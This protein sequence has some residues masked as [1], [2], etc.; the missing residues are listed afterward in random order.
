MKVAITTKRELQNPHLELDINLE[1]GVSYIVL[2]HTCPNCSGYGC[3][4]RGGCDDTIKLAP[5]DVLATLG[6]E[7]KPV[8]EKLFEGILNGR[9]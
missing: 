2:R 6:A 3:H 1:A 4:N 5:E 8:L 9:F 7:A